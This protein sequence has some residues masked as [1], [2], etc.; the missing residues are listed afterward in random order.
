MIGW[1]V[2][3]L[4]IGLMAGVPLGPASAAVVDT[5][6][7]RSL[8]RALAMGA[9]A[10]WVD[11]LFCLGAST[12]IGALLQG[13]PGLVS[14]LRLIGGGVLIFLG[15]VMLFRAPPDPAQIPVRRAVRASSLIAA[16]GTG[17]AISGLNPALLTTWLVLAGTVLAGLDG[18]EALAVSTGVFLGTFAWFALIAGFAHR[19]RASLGR[20]A[21]WFTRTAGLLL[22]VY[23]LFLLVEPLASI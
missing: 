1:F 18:F 12:G 15:I 21:H 5:A 20:R 13:R 19:G 16:A 17:V 6:L 23:G 14:T 22:V 10:A 3:G 11:F 8:G 9:G 2:Q 7:R 4:A